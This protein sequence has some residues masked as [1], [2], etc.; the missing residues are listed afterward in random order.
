MG[1]GG[2]EFAGETDIRL[3]LSFGKR[4]GDKAL[5]RYSGELDRAKHAMSPNP[6]WLRTFLIRLLDRAVRES[7]AHDP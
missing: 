7:V 6:S 5:L 4:I 1:V 2:G 3:L